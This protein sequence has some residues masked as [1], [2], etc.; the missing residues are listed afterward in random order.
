MFLRSNIIRLFSICIIISFVITFLIG[1]LPVSLDSCNCENFI[2]SSTSTKNIEKKKYFIDVNKP[3][4]AILVPF[5]D[6]FDELLQFAPYINK[7]LLKQNVPH[8]IFILN[9]IDRYRFNRAS[10]INTGFLFTKE[11]YDYIAMHDVDLLPLNDNLH[12]DYPETG[13]LHIASPDFHPKYHYPTF[14]GGILLVKREHFQ[15]VNG[16]SNKYWGWGLED[17][18]FYVRIKNAGLQIQRP[19]NITTGVNNTFSHIHD[20]KHRKRDTTKCYNQREE[21]RKRDYDTGLNTLKYNITKINQLIIDDTNIT[22]LN[23]QLFCD[24][25]LTPWCDCEDKYETVVAANANSK[26]TNNNPSNKKRLK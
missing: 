1:V 15:L 7:F 8:D 26:K 3:K 10:L 19:K 18:E 5:R 16:M 11:N 23:I 9:Q 13:P 12:Y 6:R 17:D 20:R 24:R 22:V 25:K 4:L 2:E 14:V 21:T